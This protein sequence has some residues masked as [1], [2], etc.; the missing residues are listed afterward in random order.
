MRPG[1][2]ALMLTF[3]LG[4]ISP[5]AEMI[6]VRSV[7]AAFSMVT[8][9][10]FSDLGRSIEKRIRPTT[11]TATAIKTVR[12]FMADFAPGRAIII[13]YYGVGTKWFPESTA[14]ILC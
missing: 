5:E 13:I 1:I 2:W 3:F 14:A 10:G 11:T 6:S 8:L 7:R 4:L 9:T 12:F